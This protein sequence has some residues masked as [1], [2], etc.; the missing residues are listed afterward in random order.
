MRAKLLAFI[1]LMI[2]AFAFCPAEGA[3]QKRTL[4]LMI[5]MCGSNLES[6]SAAASADFQEIL[7][8]GFDENITV[9]IMTGGSR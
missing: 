9:L 5:Y 8:A 1:L 2:T 6:G 4:T 7:N 3:E